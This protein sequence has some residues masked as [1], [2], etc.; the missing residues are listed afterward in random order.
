MN[1][2]GMRA[3]MAVAGVYGFFLIFAQFSFVE[4]LRGAGVGLVGEKWILGV[5]AVAGIS[6]GFLAA[7]REVSP[8][9]V[10]IA[11]FGAA[12]AAA[13]A[14]WVSQAWGFGL[15]ACL[16]GM[17]LGVATVGLAVMLPAW[18]GVMWVGVGTG[19]GYAFCNLPAVFLQSPEVQ[20]WIGSG[21]ACAGALAIRNEAR[22][23]DKLAPPN[24][25]PIGAALALFTALVWMDSAA[26][27]IIQHAGELKSGTWGEGSL[28]RNVG[29]HFGFAVVAGMWMAKG[30]ARTLPAAA[31]VVLAVA[32][33]AVNHAATRGI[34][35]WFYPAGVSLYSAALVAWP[36]WFS[37]VAN[38]RAAGWRAAWLFGVAGWFGSANGIGMAQTL[39][40]VPPAFVAAAGVVVGAVM[41]I[42]DRQHWRA[43]LAVAC[44]LFVGWQCGI[45]QSRYAIPAAG[46]AAERGRKVYVSEGCIHCHS[47]YV[48]PQSKDPTFWGPPRAV[49]KV[50]A[51]EPVLIGNRRQGPDLANIGARRSENWLKLHFIDPR[52]LIPESPMPS[53][54]HLFDSGRGDDLVRYLKELGVEHTAELMQRSAAWQPAPSAIRSGEGTKLFSNHCAAC[55][56]TGGRGDGPLAGQLSRAPTDLVKGP[57]VRSSEPLELARMIKFGIVGS[58]MAGHETMPD[59]EI[60]ALVEEILKLRSR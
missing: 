12:I 13:I 38:S 20:S 58:D 53:Y 35:A 33:L 1:T 57:F 52:S 42:S 21:F 9:M 37:G 16:T 47:Q 40:Q 28:W 48:R 41:L 45:S 11:L 3:A 50:L 59:G 60:L 14:P 8:K 56:G 4:L 10:R 15:I 2:Q 17:A 31:W 24:V 25:F 22:W 6:G 29:L 49:G 43:A 32:A 54:A 30:Q 23:P 39:Q 27:F 36:G 7:W 51:E 46:S 19:L 44:V 5:M 26:F 55:H 34:A 18:C